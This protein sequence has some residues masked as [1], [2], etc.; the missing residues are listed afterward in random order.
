MLESVDVS[1]ER[2]RGRK[3]VIRCHNAR[4]SLCGFTVEQ[5]IASSLPRLTIS[6]AS[7]TISWSGPDNFSLHGVLSDVE[8][9]SVHR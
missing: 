9:L 6:C 5:V 8:L 2:L 3:S 7:Q 1:S 4:N